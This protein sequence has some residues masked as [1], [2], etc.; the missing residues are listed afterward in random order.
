MKRSKRYREVAKQIERGKLFPLTEAL[1]LAKKTST[2]K[3]DAAI[4]LHV[5][6]GIDTTKA[7]QAIRATVELPHATG[8][9][10]KIAVFAD[11]ATT[12]AALAAG[13]AHAGGAE[14]IDTIKNTEKTD[15]DVAVAHPSMMRLLGPVAKILGQRGL[16]PNPKDQTVTAD[17]VGTVKALLAGKT[18]FRSD[19]SGNVHLLVGRIS[20]PDENLRE[21]VRAL[22][23]AVKKGKPD[24]LKNEYIQSMHLTTSMGPSVRLDPASL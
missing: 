12:K 15:F 11:E 2:V 5:K 10:L 9:K 24:D 8:R 1:A 21:N 4:E 7:E 18:S 19:A 6:L 14:L 16:M 13:A 3:F 20:T 17:V 22:V 23:D